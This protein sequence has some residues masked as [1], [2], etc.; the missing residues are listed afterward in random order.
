MLP[1]LLTPA[2]S[3]D[4]AYRRQKPTREQLD[5][6]ETGRTALLRDVAHAV[7]QNETE[8]YVKN[9]VVRFLTN[10]NFGAYDVNVRQKRDLVIRTGARP[11]DPVGVIL[12]L[13]RP[14][15]AGEMVTTTNLNRRAFHELLYYYLQ[16]R[17]KHA[18]TD[19]KSLKRLV[20][21]NGYEWFLFD[22]LDFDRLFWANTTLKSQFREFD[23]KAA[24]S[25]KTSFFYDSIAAPFLE[26]LPAELPFTYFNLTAK[27]T[28]ERDQILLCKLLSPPHLLKEPFAQDANTLNRAFYEELL[29]LIGLE[30][31]KDKGRKLIQR[32]APERQQPGSLLENT[33]L[34]LD[35]ENELTNLT[36][37]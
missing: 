23:R 28:Q 7:Q 35:S 32:C 14:Q 5:T 16:D 2:Q 27:T 30:E 29:Y 11:Q 15:T 18:D 17:D 6:F 24:S 13:K 22:A 12:E 34:I 19:S 4:L 31:V 26:A 9:L 10:T 25:S 3:L 8:E 20:I 37:A 33:R 21:T 1:K 36:P